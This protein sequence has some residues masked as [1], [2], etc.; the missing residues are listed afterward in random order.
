MPDD[1]KTSATLFRL[2]LD[3]E[4]EWQE[5]MRMVHNAQRFLYISTYYLEYDPYGIEFLDGLIAACQ[6]QVQAVLLIDGF[7][8]WLAGNL[9]TKASERALREKL[10]LL[11]D[12]GGHVVYYRPRKFL[13]RLCGTGFHSKYQISEEGT[14][15]FAS[16]NI[17]KMSFD[18]WFEFALLVKG[19]VVVKMMEDFAKALGQSDIDL[20]ETVAF[21]KDLPIESTGDHMSL[22]FLAYHPSDDPSH[23]SPIR[24]KVQNTITR[25]LIEDIHAAS[26]S[27]LLTSFYYKPPVELGQAVIQA[28]RRGVH[29]E[30]HHSHR[31]ALGGVSI[32]P[33]VSA[34]AEYPTLLKEK[35][36]IY[37]HTLGQHTKFVL[38]DHRC[39]WLGSYNFERAADDRLA[40]A[41]IV[42]SDPVAIDDIRHF[43]QTL[44]EDDATQHVRRDYMTS[45]SPGRKAYRLA[46]L[47][48]KRWL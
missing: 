48:V 24:Q 18:R 38:I 6:R 8:Q 11:R 25:R 2:I 27:I 29:V 1:T 7:G 40:E 22:E 33:W 46:C 21:I 43:F 23:L 13:Q 20:T 45:L 35:I 15:I 3:R 19:P 4:Q 32:L 31:D 34:V 30:I 26:E 39:A 14:A 16:G 44:R 5:R 37:E 36:N 17:S 9:M 47:P 41:M 12:S 42:T 28:A 10:K